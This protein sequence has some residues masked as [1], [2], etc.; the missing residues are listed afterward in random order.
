MGTL[1]LI[2]ALPLGNPPTVGAM[3]ELNPLC[4]EWTLVCTR[5]E[6]RTDDGN[7]AI[8]MTIDR[9]GTVIF[10]LKQLVTNRGTLRTRAVGKV[11][12]VD[13]QTADGTVL[14]G[15]ARQCGD[16]LEVCFAEAG[17]PRPIN[18]VPRGSQWSEEWRRANR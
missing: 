18:L 13:L 10:H 16:R 5:D 8:R 11:Y 4:G 14:E 17:K 12:Y 15:L 2:L 6:K 1:C 7:D 9:E 3:E